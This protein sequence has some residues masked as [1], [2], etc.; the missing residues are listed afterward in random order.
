MFL[1][2]LLKLLSTSF[3][4]FNRTEVKD[5]VKIIQVKTDK[6]NLDIKKL[7]T[8]H[9]EWIGLMFEKEFDI[10]LDIKLFVEQKMAELDKFLPPE[11]CL[12]LGEYE[13]QI[14]GEVCMRKI[15]DDLSEVK[16]MYVRPVFRGKGI[17]KALLEDL[18]A[19]AR[20]IGYSR[21]RL[22]TGPFMKVA[23]T[24]YH[25]VG[26]VEIEPYS[27]SEVPQELHSSWIFMEMALK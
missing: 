4:Y 8:E 5:A 10:S 19:K 13:N 11:G 20:Y 23:Q 1:F 21:I 18:I 22:D 3:Q 17:G 24:F 9:L 12:L 26:F 16:S 2:F 6:Y 7:F 25:S 27:E 14:A 15:G